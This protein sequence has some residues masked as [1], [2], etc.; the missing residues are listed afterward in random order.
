MSTEVEILREK[1]RQLAIELCRQSVQRQNQERENFERL[2]EILEEDT[3]GLAVE[4][5]ELGDRFGQCC[6]F[7]RSSDDI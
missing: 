6:V 1:L 4:L 3:A 7:Q 5:R 2:V